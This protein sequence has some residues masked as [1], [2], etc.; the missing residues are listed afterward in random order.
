MVLVVGAV[1]HAVAVGV[2]IVE[3]RALVVQVVRLLLVVHLGPVVL[4]AGAAAGLVE[5]REAVGV[6]VALVVGQAAVGPDVVVRGLDARRGAVRLRLDG[7]AA[8]HVADVERDRA[9]EPVLRRR[10][11][12]DV[13]VAGGV[14]PGQE[15]GLLVV[16]GGGQRGRRRPARVTG[17]D[18]VLLTRRVAQPAEVARGALGDGELP[19][20]VLLLERQRVAVVV[21]VGVGAVERVRVRA[22]G[23]VGQVA[24]GGLVLVV[25]PVLGRAQLV[26]VLDGVAVGVAPCRD[27]A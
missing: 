23:G 11:D 20:V 18:R 2:R 13:A 7:A 10:G 27:R 4:G 22:L 19:E 6:L 16:A 25:V 21:D 15:R 9:V 24:V 8:V 1:A 14:R 26:A 5:V 17:V 3:P 12:L